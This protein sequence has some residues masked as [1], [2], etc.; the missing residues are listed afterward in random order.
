MTSP[1]HIPPRPTRPTSASCDARPGRLLTIG[2]VRSAGTS[3]VAAAIAARWPN[4]ARVLLAELDPAGGTLAATLGLPPEPGLVTLAAA[5][6][7]TGASDRA[8]LLTGHAQTVPSVCAQVLV[9]PPS[10]GR[11]RAALAMFDAPE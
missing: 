1:T 7:R 4:P 3:T 5:M 2:C 8:G 10:A 9:G 11:A 6:R